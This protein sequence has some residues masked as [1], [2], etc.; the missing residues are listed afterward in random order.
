MKTIN[1]IKW[2]QPDPE[3]L[4][5][6]CNETAKNE[7]NVTEG[8]LVFSFPLCD[9]CSELNESQLIKALETDGKKEEL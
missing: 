4:C 2:I 7:V 1:K 8:D 6:V 5:Y 3:L 9:R